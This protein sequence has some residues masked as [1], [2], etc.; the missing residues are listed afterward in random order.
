MA[1]MIEIK[2]NIGD[3]IKRTV[4]CGA[5]VSYGRGTSKTEILQVQE[6]KIIS[7]S[8]INRNKRRIYYTCYN[9]TRGIFTT[10]NEEDMDE[11]SLI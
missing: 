5:S 9:E 3:K 11:Y 1:V 10:L 7:G 8:P 4:H 6:I 2:F